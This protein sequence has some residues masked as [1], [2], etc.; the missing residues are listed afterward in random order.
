LHAH[1]FARRAGTTE[2]V[3][4]PKKL[5]RAFSISVLNAC[6]ATPDTDGRV[7]IDIQKS[8]RH[9]LKSASSIRAAVFRPDPLDRVRS[10]RQF[11]QA[12]RAPATAS[13][14]S[15][16]SC[17][18]TAAPSPVERSSESGTVMLVKLPRNRFRSGLARDPPSPEPQ[19]AR[20]RPTKAAT[21][22]ARNRVAIS[23]K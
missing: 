10:I 6:E 17:K 8:Q 14:S 5:E 21:R 4:D 15:P 19:Q 12:Q 18:T 1:N 16:K 13:R 23:F 9:F 22:D 11:R 3:F 7:V 20:L 2:G